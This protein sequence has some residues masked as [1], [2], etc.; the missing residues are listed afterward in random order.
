MKTYLIQQ[1][2]QPLVNQYAVYEAG[3]DGE[4]A[5]MV[6]FAQQ[7]RLSFKEKITI[8]TDDSKQSVAFE[9]KARQ[10]IDLGAR[11]D[12]TDDAGN[13]LGVIGK[14]FASSLLRSTW[15]IFQPGQEET[16]ALRV[17]ERSQAIAIARRLWGFVPI[18]S[19]FPF[20][21]KYHFDFTDLASQQIV[22][23]YE[24]TTTVRDHYRLIIQESADQFDPRVLISLG[25]MLDALQSR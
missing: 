18:L 20:F 4:P 3:S 11:Y 7:K 14:D 25:I 12:I 19:E 5:N 9:I 16:P 23:N 13:V 21:I 15:L 24:K 6:G 17:Q 2:I 1:K 10:V 8:Y 22:A